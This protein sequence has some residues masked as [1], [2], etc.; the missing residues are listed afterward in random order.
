MALKILDVARRGLW[1]QYKWLVKGGRGDYGTV[2][3]ETGPT[4]V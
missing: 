3:I 4:E 2:G 1:R